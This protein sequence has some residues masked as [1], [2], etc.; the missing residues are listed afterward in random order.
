MAEITQTQKLS[1]LKSHRAAIRLT[2]LRLQEAMASQDPKAEATRSRETP[3]AEA[4][5]A[6]VPT[7]VIVPWSLTVQAPQL[8]SLETVAQEG[9]ETAAV[10]RLT[11]MSPAMAARAARA[12]R[13]GPHGR[14]VALAA[15]H[16]RQAEMRALAA[17][18]GMEG[19]H[20]TS[21]HLAVTVE[22]QA[23]QATMEPR[24]PGA[25]VNGRSRF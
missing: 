20:M 1:S 12:P 21:L 8:P 3:Q 4:V 17:R 24:S 13:G 16:L 25:R 7:D 14:P 9:Q 19:T 23:M 15:A 6:E 10:T 11:R 18:G 2:L 5:E 22:T